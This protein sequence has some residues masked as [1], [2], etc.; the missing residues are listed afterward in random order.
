MISRI[1]GNETTLLFTK[2]V[3]NKYNVSYYRCNQTGYIQTEQP[4][5]L[6]E[7]YESV[8]TKL[9][10]GLAHRNIEL[11]KFIEKFIPKN[12]N[13]HGRFLDFAGGYGLLTRI[14]RDRGFD[15]WT[16]DQYCQNIFSPYNDIKYIQGDYTFELV[17]AFEVLEHFEDP[18]T[19]I[20]Q[21]LRYS[22]HL[23]FSTEIIPEQDNLENWWY[24]APETGQHVSF[25]TLKALEQIAKMNQKNFYSNGKNLHLFTTKNFDYNPFS[26]L[27]ERLPYIYRKM[28]KWILRYENKS[29]L[30][31]ASLSERDY[32]DIKKIIQSEGKQLMSD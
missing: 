18:L 1:T 27:E 4:Y 22:E 21:P 14:L 12:F 29:K 25:Y 19:Q 6:Q 9:D 15:Y 2:K 31:L 26:A 28:K 24:F 23:L 20:Q 5:W 13:P 16:T 11:S 32:L 3:L 8:I 10:I 30:S 7:A 17:S